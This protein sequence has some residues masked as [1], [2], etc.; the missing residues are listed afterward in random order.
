VERSARIGGRKEADGARTIG[1]EA[2]REI[3]YLA[4]MIHVETFYPDIARLGLL[5]KI[6]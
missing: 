3:L 5:H 2:R 1:R 4:A 6:H